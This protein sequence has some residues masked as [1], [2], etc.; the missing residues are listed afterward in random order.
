MA[1]VLATYEEPVVGPDGTSYRAQAC[2]AEAEDGTDRWEGWIEFVPVEGGA[3]VRSR[4]ETTQPNRTDTAYWATGLS[5]V[6]LEGAL[7]RTLSP[8]Q[9]APPVRIVAPKFDGPAPSGA[10]PL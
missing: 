6:Y 7:E 9:S 1:E 2:G 4:R 8:A 10:V 5:P 3:P